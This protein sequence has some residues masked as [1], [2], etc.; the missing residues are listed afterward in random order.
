M[1]KII[2]SSAKSVVVNND[3]EDLSAA[4]LYS[5]VSA[6][7]NA[8]VADVRNGAVATP[9]AQAS[10]FSGSVLQ[11]SPATAMGNEQQKSTP[12]GANADIPISAATVNSASV[13]DDEVAKTDLS[14][15]SSDPSS[16]TKVSSLTNAT[17]QNLTAT[18][19][20][21]ATPPFIFTGATVALDE[22]AGLQNAETTAVTGDSDDNDIA[23][24]QLP[25]AFATRM[26]ALGVGAPLDA[27]E[28]G[29]NGVTGQNV[30]T[31]DPTAVISNMALTD[32]AGHVLN[33][34][35]SDLKTVDGKHIYLY[36]DSLDKN[37]VLGKTTG[38]EIIFAVYLQ[39]Q[40]TPVLGGQLWTT[41]YSPLFNPDATNPDDSINL[42]GKISVTVD[43]ASMNT[44]EGA[45]AGQHLFFMVGSADAG[46]VVTGYHPANQ[47]NGSRVGS[48]DTVNVSHAGVGGSSIGTNNQMINSPTFDKTGH[49]ATAGEGMIFTFVTGPDANY[50]GLNLSQAE[51]DVE[52]NIQFAGLKNS[53]SAFFLVSQLQPAKAATIE[54]SAL[55]TGLE[56]GV[57]YIDG[58]LVNDTPVN[59]A[60]VVVMNTSGVVVADSNGSVQNH[61]LGITFTNGNAFVSGV[62]EG[63]Q[64][65][66]F[67]TG[68]HNRVLIQNAGST[69]PNLNASFDIGNF[70]FAG[71]THASADVGALISFEDSA[72]TVGVN[73]LVHLDDAA[74]AGG[75]GGGT[76]DVSGTSGTL[77]HNFGTDGQG[78]IGWLGTGAPTGFTYAVSG[79]TL[80]IK[81]GSTTVVTL[82]LD[83][84]TGGYSVVQNANVLHAPGAGLN[85][86]SFAVSYQVTD[87]DNDPAIGILNVTVKDDIPSVTSNNLVHLDDAALAGGSGGGTGDILNT[88]GIL[89]H[90]FGADGAGALSWVATGAP[91]GFTYEVSGNTLQ[92]KEGGVT[93]MTLTL[94]PVT[95][96][97]SVVQNAA[98]LHIPGEGTN[99]E[100]FTVNYQ[101][102]DKDS[103]PVNG[104]LVITVKDDIPS[105]SSNLVVHLDDAALTGGSG[106]GTGDISNTSGTLAHSYGADGA[107]SIAWLNTGAP[108]GFTYDVSGTTLVVKEADVTVVT[109]T[110]DPTT[111]AYTVVQ[112]TNVIHS[113][114][115]GTNNQSFSVSYQV[116]DKDSDPVA[117][118]LVI[119][120]KDDIPSVGGNL[121]VHLDDAA[122]TGGSGGGTGDIANVTGT[123]SHSFGADGA[124]SLGWATTGAP[125]GYVYEVS[126]TTL[127][128]KEAGITVLTLTI[129]S[130]T[131]SYTVVQNAAL[132]HTP[133]YGANSQAFT[134]NYQVIDKDGDPIDGVLNITV[135]DD[136]P[137]VNSNYAV[138][139][140]DAA[141]PGGS[142]GGTGDVSNTTGTLAHGYGADGAGSIGWLTTDAPAGFSYETAG[143]T[144]YVKE[145]GVTVM[146][147]TLDP[148]TGDYSVVQN[149]PV[150]HATGEGA[151]SQTFALNYQVIDKDSDPVD[152]V[153]NIMVKDDIPSVTSNL[154]VELDDASLAGG[155]GGGTIANTTGTLAHTF[156]ADGAGSIVWLDTGAPAGFTYESSGNTMLVKEAGVT[157]MT[158]IVDSATGAYSVTQNAAVLHASDDGKNSQVFDL[159]YRVTDQDGDS[160]GGLLVVTVRDDIPIVSG[161]VLVHL[162]DAALPGGSGGGSG[163]V[164]NT[165][166]TLSH[167]FGADGA[168]LIIWD[169]TGAPAGFTYQVSGNN[170]H[171]IQNATTVITLT[172]DPV[173]GAYTAVQNAAV[174]HALGTDSQAFSVAYTVTDKDAD[175]IDG[176]LNITVK[177]DVPTGSFNQT[178]LLD[179]AVLT[180]GSGGVPGSVANTTGTLDHQYNADSDGRISWLTTGAP[181]GFTYEA[182]GDSLFVKES[183][184]LVMTL[185]LTNTATGEYSV[186][187]NAPLSH[188]SGLGT[189]SQDFTVTYLVTDHDGDTEIGPLNISV[190]DD[191]PTVISNAMVHLDD[192][193]LSGGNGGGSG[194]VMNLTGTLG[195]HYGADGAGSIVWLATG[196]PSGFTYEASG[197]SLLVKEAGTTVMTLG[198]DP[199][200]GAYTVVQNAAIL[201]APGGGTNS[202]GFT[203]GYQVVDADGDPVTGY[204]GVTVKDDVP[205]IH[206][207]SD[208]SYANTDNPTPGGSGVFSYSIGADH[209]SVYSSSNS[210][211]SIF[212]LLGQ[213]GKNSITNSSALWTSEDSN[214]AHFALAFDYQPNENSTMTVHA[215]GTLSF[216]KIAG[217]YSIALSAPIDSY[218]I[219]TTSSALAFIGYEVN[220][221]VEDHTQPAVSV[222]Q[223]STNLFAQ[224]TGMSEPDGG[225]GVDNLQAIAV[226]GSPDTFVNGE[227]FT[228]ASTWVS[229]SNLAN[230][231]AG[232]TLQKGEVLDFN[233][234]N[235]NPH[236][237]LGNVP[238]VEASSIFLKFD[239]INKE[240]LVVILKLE[241][242]VDGSHTTKALVIDNSD[243]LKAGNTITSN[244]G[245]N[246]DSNDGA[247]VIESNDFNA[248]GQHYLITGAQVLTSTEDITGTGIDF[249]SAIG[250]AG[251]STTT[252]EMGAATTDNDVIKVSDIGIVTQHTSTLDSNL[253]IA[254]AV[255]DADIDA[256][257]TQKLNVL[258]S[259]NQAIA[260]IV[261]DMNGDGVIQY[262]NR[263][264][265]VMYD[266]AQ[267]GHPLSTA[268]VGPQDG[269][270]AIQQQD[271][272]LG[273][274]FSTQAGETDLQGLAKVY[275]TNHDNIL[276][277]LDTHFQ[278]FGVWQDASSNGK[279]DSGEFVTLAQAGITSIS[280]VSN[281]VTSTTASGEVQI[282]GQ[283]TFVKADGSVGHVDDASFSVGQLTPATMVDAV[284]SGTDEAQST[285][286][287]DSTLTLTDVIHAA[288]VVTVSDVVSVSAKGDSTSSITLADLSQS[289]AQSAPI[290]TQ[291]VPNEIT[292]S[293]IVAYTSIG[294]LPIQEE[295]IHATA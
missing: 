24:N 280:L 193:V 239:G 9:V 168:G 228:Q 249:N 7:N 186:V 109:V 99:S 118:V 12:S 142:G 250:A 73:T 144:L 66:Y 160:M 234:Y 292:A 242:S 61:N 23:A 132:M 60:R 139:L 256:T 158:L 217:T 264:A 134:V 205:V 116:I 149:A 55:T 25:S 8:P 96:A 190:K 286:A 117:G 31:I 184:L 226:D 162:D 85:S 6:V 44:L 119:D 213:V 133:D 128:I 223:L 75:S 197:N 42:A 233:L 247:I 41:L 252:E 271:H 199:A 52:A 124:G 152:G 253:H 224:F 126:G 284:V 175:P 203:V 207:I 216:D 141:L 19:A 76:G 227:L 103:D 82:T 174:D 189:N 287:A 187:Q 4:M 198:L 53:D 102:M 83:P 277:A 107:G 33:G 21:A 281:N 232:D 214:S 58:L 84:A 218:S 192:A 265:G 254:L 62:L 122:M 155:N 146:T 38:G 47:S 201:H 20:L 293:S 18:F 179:D 275:D 63:Y 238:T 74:L 289:A 121:L 30:F 43:G 138:H 231:V 108:V 182:T 5:S 225:T 28:S 165:T 173:T 59:I 32:A 294:V 167:S 272:S 123:L 36:N 98:V 278:D 97:Y 89:A 22:S 267:D 26:T 137:F 50:T 10:Q 150:M 211:F 77:V 290:V 95:G 79:T 34:L 35:D 200:T 255:K 266:Y 257:L 204:L 295:L 178:V 129:D 262:L 106:G 283:S 181:A 80:L 65:Q 229:T 68:N 111:G 157:V 251:A 57:N 69:N 180:G 93:A 270:L 78:S 221:T 16:S 279:V 235:S 100:A 170:L 45:T 113:P 64:I 246:L 115:D 222:A 90:A 285:T 215:T 159:D 130:A 209:R 153:L 1:A 104:V 154:L 202:Q 143:T 151:N 15:S 156:G 263:S 164:Q 91:T 67:T 14:V 220:S 163:D 86:Q 188:V 81:E 291:D 105:V 46:L 136:I 112:N 88:T 48:G 125:T 51:A 110:L 49:V 161:N 140:D 245:I 171:V 208:A 243:I 206:A 114:A 120:V 3:S 274:V 185:T 273:I 131:G 219:S 172:V 70:S 288:T 72:P 29:Y 127:L 195:H 260:P 259:G 147:V 2:K 94:D 56:T 145:A 258:I 92:I 148:A 13:T 11:A 237:Y 269:L 194:D 169:V 39:Q 268:W 276:S 54:I 210:D 101:V 177:D 212:S 248:A 166:G 27:A 241:D 244:Y 176:V 37:L 71:Y 236:G 261:L 135:K 183:G 17:T 240:N 40:T 87:Q 230:G 282:I 196:A 191:V